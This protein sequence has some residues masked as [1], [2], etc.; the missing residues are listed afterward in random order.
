MGGGYEADGTGKAAEAILGLVLVLLTLLVKLW[1]LGF[2]VGTAVGGCGGGVEGL[3]NL[4]ISYGPPPG[5]FGLPGEAIC[6]YIRIYL[7]TKQ[8]ASKAASRNLREIDLKDFPVDSE[9]R[10]CASIVYV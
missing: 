6:M 7:S 3:N 8:R 1:G 2:E 5:A 10:S 9:Q 4:F